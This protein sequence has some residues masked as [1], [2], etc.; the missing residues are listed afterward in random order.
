MSDL[1]AVI[2]EDERLARQQLRRLLTEAEVDIVGEA[3][4]GSEAIDV[5]ART[6][7]DV[8]F[9]DI[10]LPGMSGIQLARSLKPAPAIVFTTAYD[11]YALTAFDL[12]AADYLLKPFGPRQIERALRRVRALRR[13]G[14]AQSGPAPRLVFKDRDR[15]ITL[16]V[17]E[18]VRLEARGDYVRVHTAGQNHLVPAALRELIAELGA[19]RFL[20]IHRSHAVN[21][22]YVERCERHNQK[23]YAVLLTNGGRLIASAAGSRVLRGRLARGAFVDREP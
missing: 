2:V 22:A 10:R 18:I 19:K 17:N 3:A 7:P 12:E 9:L 14:G 15:I 4:N 20:R 1:K 8:L 23:R 13:S 21:L 5:I 16:P 6:R 11:G